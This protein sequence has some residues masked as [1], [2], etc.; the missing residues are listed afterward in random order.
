MTDTVTGTGIVEAV[1]G[2]DY[3]WSSEFVLSTAGDYVI[4]QGGT[5]EATTSDESGTIDDVV[6]DPGPVS[7]TITAVEL[8]P[9]VVVTTTVPRPNN[10]GAPWYPVKSLFTLAVGGYTQ[11][12]WTD[13]LNGNTLPAIEQT[14][15]THW[16]GETTVMKVV[17]A[18][19]TQVTGSHYLRVNYYDGHLI[20]RTI[21]GP[22]AFS[23]APQFFI[24]QDGV[25]VEVTD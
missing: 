16:L 20:L 3:T 21:G 14:G 22:I 12:G 8:P 23:I 6:D 4:T 2:Q 10:E 13:G 7:V 19:G 24:F 18:E 5:A 1:A 15:T 25:W 11:Y 9:P 17:I